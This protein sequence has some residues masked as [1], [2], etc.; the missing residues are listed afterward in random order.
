MIRFVAAALAVTLFVAAAGAAEPT[1]VLV[2]VG[3][4][5]HA[6]GTHE[7]AAGGRV[8]AHLVENARNVESLAA[9]VV[10]AW[11]SKAL[12]EAADA[13]VLIGDTF[14]ANRLPNPKR[15][16]A[17][18]AQMMDRGVGL[19]AVHY[20]TGLLGEDVTPEGD[21]PLLRWMG[22]YF[23]NRSCPH[24]ESIARIYEAATIEPA[25]PDHPVSRGWKT[26]TVHDE[27]Y[28]NNYFGPDENRPAENVTVVAT[29]MLPPEAPR[30]EA[31]AWAVERPDGGRGFGVVMP[32]FYKNWRDDD[33]RRMILNAIV[34][35]AGREVPAG[36]VATAAPDL[37]AFEPEAVEFE[38]RSTAP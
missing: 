16:L 34:W 37:A 36:G 32:H 27:P 23:A 21:H 19:V 20:A 8:M 14:P 18:L 15:N 26:F 17:D 5:T 2:I 38:P 29:S 3:P 13:V 22:G 6:P 25:A 11:P 12:R 31:V 9:D 1:R 33:L 4:S 24:H 30:R 28:I 7:V 35:A 10:Y